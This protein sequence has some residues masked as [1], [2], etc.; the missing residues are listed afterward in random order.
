MSDRQ[1]GLRDEIVVAHQRATS[2]D[3]RECIQ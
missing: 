1:R 2:G 3:P